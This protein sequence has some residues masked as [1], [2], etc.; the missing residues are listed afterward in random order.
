M[1][2]IFLIWLHIQWTECR[3]SRRLGRFFSGMGRANKIV[4]TSFWHRWSMLITHYNLIQCSRLEYCFWT[5]PVTDWTKSEVSPL[6]KQG[7]KGPFGMKILPQCNNPFL[8]LILCSCRSLLLERWELFG[9]KVKFTS[10]QVIYIFIALHSLMMS[11]Y[12]YGMNEDL[13]FVLRVICSVLVVFFAAEVIMKYVSIGKP[14]SP[15]FSSDCLALGQD[16]Q[17]DLEVGFV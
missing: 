9:G 13:F 14:A 6:K 16:L 5:V 11:V 2:Y 15:Q 17:A 1:C 10:N 8:R 7:K 3:R 12:F 4:C